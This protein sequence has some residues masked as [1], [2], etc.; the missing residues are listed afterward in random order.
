MS[1]PRVNFRERRSGLGDLAAKW[2]FIPLQGSLTKD[3]A[4]DY[5]TLFLVPTAIAL[6]AALLLGLFFRPPKELQPTASAA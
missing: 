1:T 3:G 2:I 4:I 5:G 6:G